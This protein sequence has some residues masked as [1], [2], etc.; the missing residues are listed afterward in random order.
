[1]RDFK[2]QWLHIIS[3][4]LEECGFDVG[5]RVDDIFDFALRHKIV[6]SHRNGATE[7]CMRKLLIYGDKSMGLLRQES[8]LSHGG[9]RSFDVRVQRKM[10]ANYW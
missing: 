4:G 3:G 1:M 2:E 8:K 7:A 9:N 6:H 5:C 10:L